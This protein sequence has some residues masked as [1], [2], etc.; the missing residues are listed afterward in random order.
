[1]VELPNEW[2]FVQ[3]PRCMLPVMQLREDFGLGVEADEPAVVYPA[4]HRISSPVPN[5]L[6]REWS[7]ARTC[8]DA[9]AYTA[10][11]V[12]VRRTVEGTCKEQG[13]KHLG[14]SLRELEKQG[15]IDGTLAKWADALRVIG[16]Q[17]AHYTGK[18]VA[19]EDA[20][21]SLAFAE[22]L[23]DHLYVLRKRFEDF[24]RRLDAK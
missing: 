11:V 3:C 15:L 8:F 10:C 14:A 1:M 18:P 13:V 2:A 22:A 19:R 21:D 9:K 6:R 5:A 16:N 20:E 24:R 12:M 7:E 23:L 17:G 4:P